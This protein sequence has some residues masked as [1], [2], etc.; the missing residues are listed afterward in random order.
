ME[1][2]DSNSGNENERMNITNVHQVLLNIDTWMNEIEQNNLD[3]L[4]NYI[5]NTFALLRDKRL[6]GNDDFEEKYGF[7]SH[8]MND[9]IPK[10]KTTI[11]IIKNNNYLRQIKD[12]TNIAKF[13]A[14]FKGLF[15]G[16]F[17][18]GVRHKKRTLKRGRHGSRRSRRGRHS[19]K[20]KTRHS[21]KKV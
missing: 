13:L 8:E 7:S 17:R 4:D 1:E 2:Y 9:L 21:K 19:K 6:Y 20:R 10:I 5:S 3:N 15:S 16:T 14:L 12:R 18:G 11:E